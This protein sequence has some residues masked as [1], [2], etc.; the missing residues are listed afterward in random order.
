MRAGA[1]YALYRTHN[2]IRHG[3]S[4]E[5]AAR[6]YRG[7]AQEALRGYP[8]LAGFPRLAWAYCS[9][10]RAGPRRATHPPPK[11]KQCSGKNPLVYD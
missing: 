10:K 2:A 11:K 6:T 7:Y 1:F 9:A 3:A 4:R 5:L 8:T